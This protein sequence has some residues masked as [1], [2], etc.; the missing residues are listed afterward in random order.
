M[1]PARILVHGGENRYILFATECVNRIF[2]RRDVVCT[3]LIPIKNPDLKGCWLK[4]DTNIQSSE[5]LYIERESK[6]HESQ[7]YTCDVQRTSSYI[8]TNGKIYVYFFS[9]FLVLPSI[10]YHIM[11]GN[12]LDTKWHVELDSTPPMRQKEKIPGH[13]LKGYIDGLIAAKESCPVTLEEFRLGN[14]IATGCGHVFEK[15]ALD[16]LSACPL[17]RA[18]LVKEEFVCL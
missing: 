10:C 13:V 9:R 4:T 8:E 18:N 1:L 6:R 16:S 15:G 7:I 17:C 11:N 14:I 2:Q 3:K 5:M 12:Y